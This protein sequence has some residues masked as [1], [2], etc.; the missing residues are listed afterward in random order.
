MWDPANG[1]NQLA[2]AWPGTAATHLGDGKFK[3]VVPTSVTGDPSTWMI[4]WNGNGKQTADLTFTM[5]GL[6]NFNGC[7]GKVTALCEGGETPNPGDDPKPE[8]PKEGITVKAKVPAHWT[9][10]ISAWVWGEGI[11][12]HWATVSKDGEWYV[13]TE[14]TSRY[15]IIF[16][17]GND[18]NGNANQTEDIKNITQNTCYQ[19]N[20]S[21]NQKA[22]Y[23]I[24]DCETS[25]DV[26]DI[27]SNESQVR[28]LLYNGA[29]YLIM[30]NGQ[31]Y[32][33]YGNLIR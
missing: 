7:N 4:I 10:T 1:N 9:N 25:T 18:W 21:G 6:Y 16:V 26:E 23:T 32:D 20:Q 12:D 27:D 19:L 8:D 2:G 11:S 33:V 28:K 30:P 15:N 24:V 14:N 5:H 29:L 22:T 31:V 3:F 17:N 13:V